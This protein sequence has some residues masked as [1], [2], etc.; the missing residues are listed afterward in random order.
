MEDPITEWYVGLGGAYRIT[1]WQVG[2]SKEQNSSFNMAMIDTKRKLLALKRKYCFNESIDKSGLICLINL[3]LKK[4]F[5][6]I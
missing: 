5:L 1:Y 6:L 4:R 2:D 3:A